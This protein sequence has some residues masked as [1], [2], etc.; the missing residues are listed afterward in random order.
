[1]PAF[2]NDES[3]AWAVPPAEK[4]ARVSADTLWDAEDSSDEA[5]QHLDEVADYIDTYT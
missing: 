1:M 4:R 3:R 5:P 2:Q